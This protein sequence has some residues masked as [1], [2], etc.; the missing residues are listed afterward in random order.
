MASLSQAKVYGEIGSI[1]ALLT[2]VPSVGGLLGIIGFVLILL[3]VRNISQVLDDES[4]F[5]N[6]VW[7]VVLAVIGIFVGVVAVIGSVLTFIGYGNLAS[8]GPE[9]NPAT[10]PTN[11]WIGLIGSLLLGLVIVWATLLASAVFIR[12]AYSAIGSRLNVGYFGTAGLL[13]L[14]GAATTILLFGFVLLFVA[15]VVLVIAFFSIRDR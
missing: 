15:Q 9:F 14:L 8:F 7:A 11:T 5:N 12:R 6:M 1:L 4:I 13:Y 10:V 3:A 2:A